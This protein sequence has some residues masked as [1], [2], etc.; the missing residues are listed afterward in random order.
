MRARAL[1]DFVGNHIRERLILEA[2]RVTLGQLPQNAI[3]V[4]E[5]V[6]VRPEGR[7]VPQHIGGLLVRDGR[8]QPAGLGLVLAIAAPPEKGESKRVK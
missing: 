1:F 2:R 4:A 3:A 5:L 7:V 6:H 8:A